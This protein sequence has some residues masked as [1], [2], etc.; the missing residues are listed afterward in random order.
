MVRYTTENILTGKAT[1]VIRPRIIVYAV[2]L[3]LITVSAFTA[4]M[5][6][7]PLALDVIRDRNTLFRENN[8]GMIENVYTLKIMNMDSSAHEYSLSVTGIDG[9]ELKMDSFNI[10][11]NSGEVIEVP[12]RAVADPDKLHARSSKISFNLIAS[13]SNNLYVTEEAR[14]LGPIPQ[15]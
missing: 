11:V 14:F 6:R 7:T 12:V 1:H 13:D 10:E 4:I 9:L 3:T 8:D 2:I 15:H 5:N